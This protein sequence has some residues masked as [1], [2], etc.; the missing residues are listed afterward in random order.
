MGSLTLGVTIA[1]SI[2]GIDLTAI[3]AAAGFGIG[4]AMQDL[5]MN[6]MAGVLILLNRQFTIGDYIQVN[7]T[8]GQVQEIQS[9]STVLKALDGT[10][11][12]VPNADLFTN[13]VTSYTSNPFRRIE[14]GVGVEYRTD[15]GHA[16]QVI[17]EALRSHNL[18]VL[19]PAPAILIDEFADSSINFLIRFWVDSHS[20][21]MK[22][23][24]EVIHLVKKSFDAEGIGIP[25]PIRT[26]A[27]DKDTEDV[28]LPT[29]SLSSDEYRQ[30]QSQRQDEGEVMTSR[31]VASEERAK[32]NDI[33]APT[34]IAA[35]GGGV[36]AP[37]APKPI[38][39]N[40]SSD[41][42]D[43]ILASMHGALDD[44]EEDLAS[45]DE[46][47]RAVQAQQDAST[48]IMNDVVEQAPSAPP[49]SQTESG[50]SFL[51]AN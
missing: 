1:L 19:E 11:V 26:L 13:Q 33:K 9:R 42:D 40:A 2:A 28:L 48:P 47:S 21:W 5:I 49:A 22:T 8:I 37:V 3:I 25:F 14:I 50:A 27:F 43:E 39:E 6:F 35:E 31:V 20:N 10:K 46:A 41:N 7:D 23:K 29:Y 4:F 44:Q 16:S 15:L 51:N 45:Y 30:H 36:A 24:S 38:P 32:L 34:P 12:I 18:V 17:L